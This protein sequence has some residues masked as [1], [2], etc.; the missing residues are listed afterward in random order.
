[1]IGIYTFHVA[2]SGVPFPCSRGPEPGGSLPSAMQGFHGVSALEKGLFCQ[3][4]YE[5]GSGRKEG[6]M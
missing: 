4:G 3:R 1:M 2:F 5:P 6:F